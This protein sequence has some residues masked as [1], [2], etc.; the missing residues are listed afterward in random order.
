MNKKIVGGILRVA[1]SFSLLAL[2][3]YAMRGRVGDIIKL[4]L[5]TRLSILILAA[6]LTFVSYAFLSL[7]LRLFLVAQ[8]IMVSAKEAF[9][10]TLI[11]FFFNN[12]LPTAIGG[13]AVK[14]YYASKKTTGRLHAFT[15]V[16]MDRFVGLGTFVALALFAFLILSREVKG[17]I[18][19]WPIWVLFFLAVIA[20]LALFNKKAIDRISNV[21][22]FSWT[23]KLHSSLAA[24]KNKRHLFTK[25][26]AVSIA[27]QL[28][29]FAELYIII[30]GLYD[31]VPFVKILLL[32]PIVSLISMLPSINGLG[33]RE[34]AYL[35]LF[36]PLI[37]PEKALAL[38]LL[39]LFLSLPAGMLGGF[40]YAFARHG[41]A[42]NF[43]GIVK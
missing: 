8:G 19:I 33:V 29:F 11:G 14:A 39:W 10:L 16:F 6:A 4:I 15:A 12:F 38:G 41:R 40:V 2:L 23:E 20:M 21:R 22:F 35:L 1:V 7:R 37:G 9:G 24:F 30:K 31:F 27:A 17:K 18:T 25:A 34:G 36:A 28:F 3:L 42:E 26:T 32:A 43:N 13:D 5:D